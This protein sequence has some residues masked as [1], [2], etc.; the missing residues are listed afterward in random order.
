MINKSIQKKGKKGTD[1]FF[2]HILNNSTIFR[3][4]ESVP[5]F[6]FFSLEKVSVLFFLFVFLMI[7]VP[8][9]AVDQ[10]ARYDGKVTHEN[11]VAAL[12]SFINANDAYSAIPFRTYTKQ[13]LDTVSTDGPLEIRII[14][15]A[16][17]GILKIDN[18][19]A[20]IIL[21]GKT[22]RRFELRTFLGI[23]VLTAVANRDLKRGD[24]VDGAYDFK[25]RDLSTSPVRMPVYEGDNLQDQV[26]RV[27]VRA[28]R[29]IDQSLLEMPFL[30]KRGEKVNILFSSGKLTL[31]MTGKALE[32]GKL[33]DTIEILNETSG[34][35]ITVKVTG[36]GEVSIG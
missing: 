36:D 1:T 16:R 21:N 29:E 2:Q 18:F 23:E 15:R 14:D 27:N 6:P 13:V 30:V 7:A 24:K 11:V 8:A 32:S 28:G 20:A 25:W 17:E 5:F 3:E 33:G 22:I 34:K 31:R 9:Y 35:K 19:Q 12:E 10:D 26:M 4:K